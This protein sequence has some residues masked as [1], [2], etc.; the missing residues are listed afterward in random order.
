MKIRVGFV[1]NSSSSSF[2]ILGT[3]YSRIKELQGIKEEEPKSP[4][5]EDETLETILHGSF[6]RYVNGI[7][8]YYEDHVMG[9]D[10]GMVNYPETKDFE[11]FL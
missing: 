11:V 8:E 5:D 7:D 6:L 9:I 3:T 4:L 2:C 1:S 10:V